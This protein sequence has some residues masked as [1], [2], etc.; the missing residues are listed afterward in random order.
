LIGLNTQSTTSNSEVFEMSQDSSKVFPSAIWVGKPWILPAVVARTTLIVVV[1]V[2][3]FLMELASGLASQKVLNVPLALWTGLVFLVVWIIGMSDL[4][5]L[6]ASNTYILRNDSLEI[7]TGIFTT[8]FFAVAPSGFANMEVIRT[9]S[10]RIM[11]MGEIVIRTQDANDGDKRL[12]MIRDPENVA[13]RIRGIM[14]KPIVRIEK[15]E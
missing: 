2:V 10:G 5:L 9:V 15:P 1:L 3:I 7:R 11:N 14:S 12:V 6:R 8:K 4:L 13:D